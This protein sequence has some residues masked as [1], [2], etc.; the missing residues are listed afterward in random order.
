MRKPPWE[1][2]G[3]TGTWALASLDTESPHCIHVVMTRFEMA[4]LLGGAVEPTIS[5]KILKELGFT[6]LQAGNNES[7]WYCSIHTGLDTRLMP[8]VA[9]DDRRT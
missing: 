1:K 7:L 3:W 6:D 2:R 5:S 8:A 9:N 4:P